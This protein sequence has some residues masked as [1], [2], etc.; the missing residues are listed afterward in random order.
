M[1]HVWFHIHLFARHPESS[2]H[3]VVC[4]EQTP[5]RPFTG[6]EDEG[7]SST[8]RNTTSEATRRQAWR[9]CT[10]K[11]IDVTMRHQ[12]MVRPRCKKYRTSRSSICLDHPILSD[13]K[14]LPRKVTKSAALK[15]QLSPISGCP[16]TFSRATKPSQARHT[17][18]LKPPRSVSLKPLLWVLT[19]PM[20]NEGIC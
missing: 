12:T 1:S 7:A 8:Y 20:P 17:G 14:F 4:L 19:C 15:I 16:K 5:I 6:R 10:R 18:L 11:K 9:M 2:S 13:A 3:R